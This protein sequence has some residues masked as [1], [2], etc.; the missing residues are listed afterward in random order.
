MIISRKNFLRVQNEQGFGFDMG[1]RVVF[2]EWVKGELIFLEVDGVT[3]FTPTLWFCLLK[4]W[5]EAKNVEVMDIPKDP[6][7]KQSSLANSNTEGST[8]NIG[9]GEK[10]TG[11]RKQGRQNE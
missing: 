2:R 6:G 4:P 8:G 9:M 10:K 7:R 5:A 1:R 11:R 3:Y